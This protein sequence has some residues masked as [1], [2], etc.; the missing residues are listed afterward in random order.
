MADIRLLTE[1]QKK[2]IQSIIAESKKLAKVEGSVL[3]A[4]MED[5][6]YEKIEIDYLQLFNHLAGVK[7]IEDKDNKN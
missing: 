4:Y 5:I 7:P 6:G 2:A 1:D 3:D